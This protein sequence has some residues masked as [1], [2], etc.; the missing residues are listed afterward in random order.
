[1]SRV[2]AF[3]SAFCVSAVF[4]G[5]LYMLC[6][7][8][9]LSKSLKYILSL[10]FLLTVITVGGITVKNADID[11]DFSSPEISTVTLDNSTAK[12]VI[13]YLLEK[14][15]IEFSEIEIFTDNS[16]TQSISINKVVI[17]TAA[18]KESVLNALGEAVKNTEVEIIND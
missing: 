4:I 16:E 11:I 13:G 17:Y 10:T 2:S 18:S 7:E 1:M 12:F 6:P 3:L 14:A 15:N 5:G 8:G 9:A